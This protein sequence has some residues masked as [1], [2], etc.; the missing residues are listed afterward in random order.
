MNAVFLTDGLKGAIRVNPNENG[1]VGREQIAE[2][3]Q[4]LME[5]EEGNQIRTRMIDVKIAAGN[6]LS[7]EGSSTKALAHV[8]QQW[9]NWK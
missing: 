5:G 2:L 9:I 3:V 1:V 7:P 4:R 6:A 8:V